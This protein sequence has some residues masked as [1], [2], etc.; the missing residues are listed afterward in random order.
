MHNGSEA[1][2]FLVGLLNGDFTRT[3]AAM[4][5]VVVDDAELAWGDPMNRCLGMYHIFPFAQ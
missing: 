2:F 3:V 4:M 5:L 1:L